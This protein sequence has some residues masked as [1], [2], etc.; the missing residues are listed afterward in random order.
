MKK[1][2]ILALIA[3]ATLA[4]SI[5][6]SAARTSISMKGDSVMIVD[7]ND[8]LIAPNVKAVINNVKSALSDTVI[9]NI[10]GDGNYNGNENSSRTDSNKYRY[11]ANREQRNIQQTEMLITL[12]VFGSIVFIIFLCLTFFYLHRRAKYRMIEKAIEN[13]YELPSSVAGMYPSN[14]Q[15]PASPQPIIINQPQQP[16]ANQ[17]PYQQMNVPQGFAY[18]RPIGNAHTLPGQYNIQGFKSGAI[19]AGV[20]ICLM[21]FWGTCGADPLVALSAIPLIIGAIKLVGEFFKQRSRIE[22]ERYQMQQGINPYASQEPATG[23]PMEQP[24]A[25]QPAQPSGEVTPPPFGGQQQ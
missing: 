23:Q 19:W 2:F 13:N 12:I 16:E 22:Y 8:T 20:G 14:F 24:A 17:A 7:G 3:I 5:N 25:K 1:I 4:S 9:A 6:T 10:P 21:L 15:Q 18:G 11:L